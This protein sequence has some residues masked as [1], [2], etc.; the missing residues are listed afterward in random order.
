MCSVLMLFCNAL[1]SSSWRKEAEYVDLNMSGTQQNHLKETANSFLEPRGMKHIFTWLF[2]KQ[3][4]NV[5]LGVNFTT[6]KT[7]R[8]SA[9]NTIMAVPPEL[10]AVHTVVC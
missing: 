4:F 3:M 2:F 7:L 9:S 5:R 1:G 8:P 6:E 10:T